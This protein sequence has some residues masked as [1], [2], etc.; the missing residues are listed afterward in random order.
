MKAAVLT[1]L[2]QFEI[3]E[4]PDPVL[5]NESDVLLKVEE[6]GV[7]GSDVHYYETGRIGDQVVQFPFLVGHESSGTVLAVGSGVQGVAPGDRVAIDPAV[8]CGTCEQCR[9]GRENT[10]RKLKFLGCPGQLAGCLCEKIVMP[11][12]SCLPLV[13]GLSF[14]QGVLSEP[15]AIGVYAVLQAGVD[16]GQSVA[17]LGCGPIGLSCLISSQAQG[18]A[19][20]YMTDLIEPRLEHAR[21]QGAAWV[22]SPER[23]DVVAAIRQRAPQG[24]DVVLECAGEQSTVD[25]ALKILRPGGTL[26]MIGIPRFERLSFDI[27]TMRR[28]EIRF[29]NIRRQNQCTQTA[30]DWMDGGRL[31]PSF[32][33]THSYSLDQ[34]GEAFSLV[35][36]YQ[37]GVIKAMITL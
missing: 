25:Q 28:Q 2:R 37:D 21:S 8:V 36:G 29:L 24:V 26:A 34:T 19:A 17:I 12:A 7:C 18:A 23:E 9:R 1:A 10:C 27:H 11:A 22:G 16:A 35:A 13:R 3:Q 6:V 32:M 4:L 33:A 15:L 14:T 5:E 31:D 20:C 30:L